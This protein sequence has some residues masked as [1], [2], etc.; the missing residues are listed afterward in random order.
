[1]ALVNRTVIW[2]TAW[3]ALPIA[4]LLNAWLGFGP[5]SGMRFQ[6]QAHSDAMANRFEEAAGLF[7][8]AA[9]AE[10]ASA[11]AAY[12]A[13]VAYQKLG[14]LR[15]AEWWNEEALRRNPGMTQA[16]EQRRQLQ[17]RRRQPARGAS[18]GPAAP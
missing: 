9:R 10:P 15:N 1:M 16:L 6:Q 2:T 18:S 5:E 17:Q 11:T 4:M 8:R 3:S 14:D 7:A 13:A 12:N